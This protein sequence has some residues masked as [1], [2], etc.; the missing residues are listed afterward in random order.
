[1]IVTDASVLIALAKLRRLGLLQ[2]VY[3]EVLVGPIVRGEVI[4]QGKAVGATEVVAVEE[5]IRD[6][7]I[8]VAR[9]TQGERKATHSLLTRSGLDGGE[10][11]SM[12]L[13]RSRK[14]MLV[15]DD[16]EARALA[17]AAGIEH[18]GTAGVLLEA[19]FDGH[20]GLEELE[21]AV[22]DLSSV[23]WLAPAVAI[24]IL[25]KARGMKK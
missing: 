1:M 16:K 5:A 17:A 25:R 20:L 6:G 9:P 23:L 4:D 24:E 15:V 3:G 2:Q 10:S 21:E 22:R 14:C 12:A 11:E 19:Y 18:I 13:A 8:R 7:W